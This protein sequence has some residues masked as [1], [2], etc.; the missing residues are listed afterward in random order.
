LSHATAAAQEVTRGGHFV[1]KTAQSP[2]NHTAAGAVVIQPV[3]IMSHAIY[4]W[5][6]M[7]SRFGVERCR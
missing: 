6:D 5:H 7:P 1:R 4:R 2:V 3:E